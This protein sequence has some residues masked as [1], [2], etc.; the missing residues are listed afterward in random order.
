MSFLLNAIKPALEDAI[1]KA[2]KSAPA[3]ID[4]LATQLLALLPASI[5][6]VTA[7]FRTVYSDVVARIVAALPGSVDKVTGGFRSIYTDVTGRVVAWVPRAKPRAITL[8][9][10]LLVWA[11]ARIKAL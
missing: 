1:D 6:K 11:K 8:I 4:A 5:E 10:R 7:A 3:S 2:R 9:D